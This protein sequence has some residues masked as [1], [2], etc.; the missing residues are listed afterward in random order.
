MGRGKKHKKSGS[1]GIEGLLVERMRA[2]QLKE[3]ARVRRNREHQSVPP[4]KLSKRKIKHEMSMS[5]AIKLEG[6]ELMDDFPLFP[7]FLDP[8]PNYNVQD[9]F[10]LGNDSMSLKGQVWPGM[11]KM[12]LAD[13]ITRRARNQKKPKSVID[14]MKKASECIE[15]T[16]VIMSSKFEVER[17]KDVYDDTSSPAPGQE[18][19]TPPRKVPKPKR[20][21][22]TPLAEISGNVPKQRRRNARGQKSHV[23][24]RMGF[25]KEQE[26]QEEPEIYIPPKEAREIKDMFRDDVTRT[27]SISEPPRSLG[28][29]DHRLEPRN[30]HGARSMNGFH[31]SNLV[32]PTPQTRD[33]ASR[34][35]QARATPSTIR[36]EPFPPGSFSHAEASYAMK[37]ATI[38]NASSRL[39]FLPTS[40]SQFRDTGSDHLR[41]AANYGFQLKEDYPTPHPGELSQGTNSQFIEMSGTNPLFSTDRSFLSSYGQGALNATFSPLPFPSINR[42]QDL[43]H[44]S[45]ETKQQTHMCEAMEAS[46]LGEEQELNLDGP[47]SLNGANSDLSFP[48]GL[49]FTPPPDSTYMAESLRGR[50]SCISMYHHINEHPDALTSGLKN[51]R[52]HTSRQ[53]HM[54][55][56]TPNPND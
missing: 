36:P 17:T 45:R 53:H 30:K 1:N 41:S 49:T 33:L 51:G 14:K 15:P 4:D 23:G 3:E 44:T 39:P 50:K 42:Q 28:H 24:K 10:V 56:S 16:Q 55:L 6:D 2:K 48:H 7:G 9:E 38:Y 52:I 26:L 35:P 54:Q 40:Y 27:A 22:L 12:D 19:S 43:P 46:G 20:K 31:H 47:W 18:E 29:G 13:D 25:K 11:G 5:P 32:S 8:E 21:K 37:D 34:H